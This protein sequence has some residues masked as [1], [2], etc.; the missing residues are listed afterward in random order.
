MEGEPRLPAPTPEKIGQEFPGPAEIERRETERSRREVAK[1]TAKVD[2]ELAAV[3][4]KPKAEPKAKAAKREAKARERREAN[5]RAAA[6]AKAPPVKPPAP[7]DHL[8]RD[9][10]EAVASL[11]PD[12]PR[13]ASFPANGVT[14]SLPQTRSFDRHGASGPRLS[15]GQHSTS[16]ASTSLIRSGAKIAG[17][18]FGG[19]PEPTGSS[20][21]WTRKRH[22]WPSVTV[23]SGPSPASQ[24]PRTSSPR[25]QSLRCGKPFFGRTPAKGCSGTEPATGPLRWPDPNAEPLSALRNGFSAPVVCGRPHLADTGDAVRS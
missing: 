17:G 4:T 21:A 13:A 12:E 6:P 16:S 15:A 5:R 1:L 11:N 14:S 25:G 3:T 8:A 23:S 10:K 7:V 24:T 22:S 19:S 2:A 20:S 9:W 18:S